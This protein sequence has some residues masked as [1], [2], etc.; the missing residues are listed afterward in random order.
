MTK[1]SEKYGFKVKQWFQSLEP[2]PEKYNGEVS[3][4]GKIW[5]PTEETIKFQLSPF[6]FNKKNTKLERL[7]ETDI[8]HGETIVDMDQFTPQDITL[9]DI[10]SKLAKLYDPTGITIPYKVYYKNALSK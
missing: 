1:F 2:K 10:A 7:E 3:I 5:S 4:A 8:F 9:R 6:H